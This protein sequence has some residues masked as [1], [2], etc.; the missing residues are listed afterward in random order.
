MLKKFLSPIFGDFA[1]SGDGDVESL[2][3]LLLSC[4]FYRLQVAEFFAV[5]LVA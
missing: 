3:D 1:D 4:L 2:I 5:W